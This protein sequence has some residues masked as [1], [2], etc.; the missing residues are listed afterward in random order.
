MVFA[1]YRKKGLD[2]VS[3]HHWDM[4]IFHF[5]GLLVQVEVS[6]PFAPQQGL[7]FARRKGKRKGT[8]F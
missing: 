6:P 1:K 5:V 8:N 3:T 4:A 2:A 7:T